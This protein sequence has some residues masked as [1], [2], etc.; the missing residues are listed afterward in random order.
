MD[1]GIGGLPSLAG[2]VVPFSGLLF[3]GFGFVDLP[4]QA[5]F[6]LVGFA[7]AEEGVARIVFRSPFFLKGLA[8]LHEV[9]QCFA[10]CCD[11]GGKPLD[12]AVRVGTL[13]FDGRFLRGLCVPCRQTFSQCVDACRDIRFRRCFGA[14]CLKPCRQGVA[15]FVQFMICGCQFLRAFVQ[16]LLCRLLP[17]RCRQFFFFCFVEGVTRPVYRFLQSGVGGVL[18]FGLCDQPVDGGYFFCGFVRC[19]YRVLCV[20]VVQRAAQRTGFAVLKA[21]TVF[22][23]RGDEL[24]VAQFFVQQVFFEPV[25]SQR[26]TCQYL[27]QRVFS[28]FEG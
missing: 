12:F 21:R 28:L 7:F 5:G 2:G 22:G 1:T 25:F 9:L 18:C 11:D 4:V 10:P 27:F 6:F 13:F 19:R 23:Q 14:E 8:F 24:D 3:G 20:G 17:A 15:V 26:V 16:P